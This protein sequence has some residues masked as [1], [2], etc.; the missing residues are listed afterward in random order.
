VRWR[1]LWLAGLLAALAVSRAGAGDS[2]I[3]IEVDYP[4]DGAAVGETPCGLFVAGRAAARESHLRRFDVAVVI[5]TSGSTMGPSGADINGNGAVGVGVPVAIGAG[6]GELRSSDPGDSI[7][8]A[9]V[10]AARRLLALVDRRIT[11]VALVTFSGLSPG[12]PVGQ[13]HGRAART[14]QPLSEDYAVIER[15]LDRIL[16]ED[17]AGGTN[18]AAGIER[19][20]VELLGLDGALSSPDP[21]SRKLVL[22][23]TDGQPTRP[24]ET[25]EANVRAVLEAA[26]QARLATLRIYS[27]ALG[28]EALDGPIASLDM[29]TLTGG[30][31]VPV[32]NAGDVVELVETLEFAHLSEIHLRSA[33]TGEGAYPFAAT[34][35]GGWGGLVPLVPGL[36]RI[37]VLARA[38]DGA[39]ARR[40]LEVRFDPAR[41]SPPLPRS[42]SFQ[43]NRLLEACLRDLRRHRRQSEAR[44]ARAIRKEL[45]VE[46]ERERAE[47]RRRAEEQRKRLRLEVELPDAP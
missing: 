17:P 15:A 44:Q 21:D 3:E 19:A 34:A 29:A 18:M 2:R 11:R 4:P 41:A 5:D 9:E 45:V 37:E 25:P 20:M 26:A 7:L 35:D 13:V 31:F 14:R 23:F 30:A 38:T 1:W 46:I 16:A 12:T 32:R 8:A 27:F 39:V 43:R 42:F 40:W 22:F 36:N 28:P 24:Y 47:A 6:L 10:A 33:T